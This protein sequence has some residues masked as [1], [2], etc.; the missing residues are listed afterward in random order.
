MNVKPQQQH[1]LQQIHLITFIIYM[2]L[3]YFYFLQ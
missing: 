1:E 2:F 3:F